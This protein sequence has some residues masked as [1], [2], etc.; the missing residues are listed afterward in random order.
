MYNSLD[1]KRRISI[2]GIIISVFLLLILLSYLYMN[3]KEN[4]AKNITTVNLSLPQINWT[5]YDMLIKKGE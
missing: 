4:Q 1:Q 5:Q 2:L 3:H